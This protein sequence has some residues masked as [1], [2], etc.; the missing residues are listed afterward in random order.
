VQWA[1]VFPLTAQPRWSWRA[2]RAAAAQPLQ[3]G[4]N[5]LIVLAEEGRS[6]SACLHRFANLKDRTDW[7]ERSCGRAL[8][9]KLKPTLARTRRFEIKATGSSNHTQVSNRPVCPA[10]RASRWTG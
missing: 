5:R 9:G 7:Y 4:E 1:G 8:Q 10:A 2:G 3:D 6:A